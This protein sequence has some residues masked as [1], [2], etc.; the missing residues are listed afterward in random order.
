MITTTIQS[1]TDQ[2]DSGELIEDDQ[3]GEE[4]TLE[5]AYEIL[6]NSRRRQTLE[7][8]EDRADPADLGELAEFIAAEE[9]DTTVASVTSKER[10]RVYVGLYQCHLPKMDKMGIVEFDKNRGT[11]EG[12]ENGRS[13]LTHHKHETQSPL[14]WL[15]V[16]LALAAIGFLGIGV[17][18]QTGSV[19]GASVLLAFLSSV[20]VLSVFVQLLRSRESPL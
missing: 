13:V 15:L 8:L 11:I 19:L 9:N 12:T 6:K 3:P 17:L 7:F 16:Y 18:S 1:A 20:L 2:F 4:I 14:R 5:E 10:K